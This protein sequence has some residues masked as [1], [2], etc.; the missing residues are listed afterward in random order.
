MS[1]LQ[2]RKPPAWALLAP[3]TSARIVPEAVFFKPK[4][5]IVRFAFIHAPP[6][7]LMSQSL[8]SH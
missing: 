8:T 3:Q 6:P 2:G 1:L 7:L 4:P 5:H